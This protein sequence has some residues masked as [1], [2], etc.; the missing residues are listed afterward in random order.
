MG[1]H[2]GAKMKNMKALVIDIGGLFPETA[3]RILRDTASVKYFAEWREAFVG[4]TRAKIGDNLDGIERVD[5]YEDHIDSV[6]F[7]F[8]PDTMCGPLVEFLKRHDYPVAGAGAAEKIELD[9]WYGRNLQ[10]KNGLP[11]Q[12]THRITGISELSKFL[13]DHKN[14]YVKIDCYRE[15]LES[16]KHTDWKS[17]EQEVDNLSL[18]LGPYKEDFVFIVEEILE[19]KEPGLDGITFDGELLYPTQGGYEAKGVGIIERTYKDAKELP[20]ALSWVNDGMAKEF[21]KSKTKFFFSMEMKIGKDR[22]PYVIDPTIRLAAPGTSAIQTEAIQNYTEVIYG[23]ATGQ[24]VIPI[25]KEKYWAA[26]A[27]ESSHAE[28]R[29][30]N[31]EVPKELRQWVKFRMAA[32]K[33][34]EYYACPGFPSICTILG[35]GNTIDAAINQVKERSKE[36]KASGLHFDTHGLDDIVKDVNEGKLLGINF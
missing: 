34:S 27:G 15:T 9:R 30:L 36:V 4:I 16:F 20:E 26:V 8:V 5:N 33:G 23:L 31:V 17:S 6:D 10:A 29:W 32:K 12:E 7:I 13:K 11:V 21:Q 24:K 18:K 2:G 3:L 25:I 1:T 28:K 22:A 14:Y 35:S 19:G